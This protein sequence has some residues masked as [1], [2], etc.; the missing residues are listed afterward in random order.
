[1]S[2]EKNTNLG[3]INEVNGYIAK[4][5]INKDE[6]PN[7]I[8][9]ITEP[10]PIYITDGKEI[11]NYYLI[12]EQRLIAPASDLPSWTVIT[13]SGPVVLDPAKN[14]ILQ[15]ALSNFQGAAIVITEDAV[16]QLLDDVFKVEKSNLTDI[17]K[18]FGLTHLKLVA[19]LIG[20]EKFKIFM[21]VYVKTFGEII[22]G[23]ESLRNSMLKELVE[24]GNSKH[25]NEDSDYLEVLKSF[26][27]EEA[28][29]LVLD[30]K[31]TGV[32]ALLKDD[33][34]KY[35]T[36]INFS[37]GNKQTLGVISELSQNSTID[38][39]FIIEDGIP[40]P[41]V[42]PIKVGMEGD[43]QGVKEVIDM[44]YSSF[45]D[46]Y[47]KI[48]IGII[49]QINEPYY[50]VLKGNELI[51]FAL[52]AISGAGK[53]NL[54]KE[55]ILEYERLRLQH[56]AEN[57]SLEGWNRLGIILFDD[58]G[59]YVKC[60]KPRDWGLDL[61]MLVMKFT[62]DHDPLIHLIDVGMRIEPGAVS[63]V[64]A[65]YRFIEPRPMKIPLRFIPV[66][67]IINNLEGKVAYG[68]IPA[69]LR[70]FYLR[71]HR[72]RPDL[73]P[74]GFNELRLTIDFVNWFLSEPLGFDQSGN[75]DQYGF[76]QTSHA[77]AARALREF[78]LNN[79]RYLGIRIDWETETFDYLDSIGTFINDSNGNQ[80][81]HEGN[82]L[83]RRLDN[84]YNLISFALCCADGGETLII[85][86]SSLTPEVKLLI[87]RVLLNYIV[88]ERERRGFDANITPTL[89]IIEEATALLGGQ[90]ATQI[91]LF[92]RTQVRARKFGLGIGLVLQDIIKLDPT[93][94]TQLGWMM[95]MG[96]PVNSMRNILFRNVPSDL[97]P[98]DDY[99]KY[100]DVGIAVG[101]QK[102]IGRNLPLPM[103]V[104]H[105]EAEIRKLL[106]NEDAW[107]GAGEFDQTV[108]DQFRT[109]ARTLN[110][111]DNAIDEILREEGE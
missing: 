99:V 86:E 35:G 40:S 3:V 58:V 49:P 25:L 8:Y 65:D 70:H 30:N 78:L 87:Q 110:I 27:S 41:S 33:S 80:I 36:L 101:F 109:I 28:A 57:D 2:K 90:G 50:I 42:S 32:K 16:P 69:Y 111:P 103:K 47:V 73:R 31:M 68:V 100:A 63:P 106:H 71:L 81:M 22:N 98:Y 107:G 37:E 13:A 20:S 19:D 39:L 44:L 95:A 82:R 79:E 7:P 1:M 17:L 51:H 21:R 59:E 55:L 76:Q 56:L 93:L 54:L 10:M 85:D 52:V 61:A 26:M 60:L 46:T 91:G 62:Y 18:E 77:T 45:D 34:Y 94:L 104:N 88:N 102:L 67:E 97:G 74:T 12:Y 66:S 83:G 5:I 89:F 96:L 75:R 108:K 29:V 43:L 84:D 48:P 11:A 53:G 23:E 14:F 15:S 24:I 9:P 64:D 92:S 38:L 4:I 6:A 105:F 72:E